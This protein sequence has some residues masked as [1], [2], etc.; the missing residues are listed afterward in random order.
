VGRNRLALNLSSSELQVGFQPKLE[1]LARDR[2]AIA[3][4]GT[5]I[6]ASDPLTDGNETIVGCAC[7][8][9][10]QFVSVYSHSTL[11]DVV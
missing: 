2:S 10:R 9:A 8:P 3:G 4:R 7:K 1:S 6:S 11:I 5:A